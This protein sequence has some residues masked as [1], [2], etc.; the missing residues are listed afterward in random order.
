MWTLAEDTITGEDL[1][2]L[3]DWLRT[4][5]RLTQG[6]LVREFER[7]WA[8]WLG[9][10]YSVMMSSGS[11]ANFALTALVSRRVER[12]R[13]RIGVAATTWST[14]VSPAL[15]LGADVVVFDVNRRTLGVDEERVC[16]AMDEDRL[17]VLFLT[18]LLGFN[19]MTPG[20]VESAQRNGVLVLEDA[21]E[22][23]GARYRDQKVGT[24]GLGSTFSFYFGHHMST[25]E[26]GMVSTSDGTLA[27]DLRMMRS[28]GLARESALFDEHVRASPDVDP[29]FLFV[30]AGLNFRSTEVNAFLGLRQLTSVDERIGARNR[31]LMELLETLPEGL[32]S[33]FLVDGVSSFAL[34]L[35]ADDRATARAV[36]STVETLAI[37]SRPVV[38][39]NLLRHPFLRHESVE[40][41]GG[42]APVADH[43]HDCGIY[44]GNGHHV[45]PQMVRELTD[46]LA[47]L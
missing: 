34:P 44:V 2:S 19:A 45:T 16:A 4:Y 36:R 6:A 31:N 43:V 38:A 27:D 21:C 39:G 9:V 3:A 15:L 22:S 42:D 29:R 11:V 20:I 28:H 10:P 24:I 33:D 17:D 13:A 1:D 5:P 23:H 12:P 14:N 32:W 35:I 25:I 18:H 40:L 47:R 37:E 8:S 46:H 26:G 7:A 30:Q 41:Y